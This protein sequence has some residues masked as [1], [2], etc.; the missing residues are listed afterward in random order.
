MLEKYIATSLKKTNINEKE[1]I[2]SVDEIIAGNIDEKTRILTDSN[3]CQYIPLGSKEKEND[4]NR[5]YC[6][7]IESDKIE[8]VFEE[9]YTFKEAL[10]AYEKRCRERLFLTS[11]YDKDDVIRIVIDK[12]NY[13]KA[14]EKIRTNE[15]HNIT[16]EK[17]PNQKEEQDDD[18][19]IDF[20]KMIKEQIGMGKH[21]EDE[22]IDL[23]IKL[24]EHQEE[25]EATLMSID[26]QLESLE[27]EY[28]EKI[29]SADNKQEKNSKVQEEIVSQM[30]KL[31]T[32]KNN[33]PINIVDVFDKVTKTLVAQDEPAR[34]VIVELARLDEMKKKGYGI[35]LTGESGVGKTLFMSLLARHLQRP[36]LRI[37]S[38]QL[39][40]P[41]FV[42]RDIEQYLW[43]LY[44]SCNKNLELAERA[45][46][47]FDE[48]D[49]KG[50]EKKSDASGQAVLNTLLTFIGG[51]TY[52]ACKHPNHETDKNS[53]KIDTSNMLIVAG[54]AFLD[55]YS[56]KEKNHPL[57]FIEEDNKNTET[58]E[59]EISDFI[60][61]AQMPKEFM[62]RVP[63]I[64]KM[65]SLN[66][67]SIR[68]ILLESDESILKMQEEIFDNRGV[69]LT[70]QDGYIMSISQAALD[71]KIGA[72]GLNKLICDTTWKAYD[73]VCSNPNEYSE[74]ILTEETVKD[75]SSYQYIKK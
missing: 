41:G 36:L 70:T 59:P 68:K 9:N 17:Q 47:F 10:E 11:I 33:Q 53:V 39:T 32:A 50:S 15:Q 75:P 30:P 44:E 43:E 5:Y 52:T 58:V 35:L 40:A 34:R 64:V 8:Q 56:N 61:K 55:V 23:K 29:S 14:L 2:F 12:G 49:K 19:Y 24:K 62:G 21:T 16:K 1:Y 60:E 69:K 26:M 7:A 31:P 63:I 25:I 38:T 57:G 27:E 66:I 51:E 71:R 42:G 46:V 65:N 37:D 22:L 48:I 3:G 6:N 18:S 4:I 28:K 74:I 73:D 13:I 45:I 72:R 67:D 20:L 54:G